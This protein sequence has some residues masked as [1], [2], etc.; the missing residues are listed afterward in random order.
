MVEKLSIVFL[1]CGIYRH[2]FARIRCPDCYKEYLLA[3]SCKTRYFCPSCQAKRVAAFVGWVTGEVLEMMVQKR[4]LS[5]AFAHKISH[6]HH[7]G[8]FQV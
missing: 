1:E 8:G 2:G 5:P 4:R 7:S 3:F 6:W